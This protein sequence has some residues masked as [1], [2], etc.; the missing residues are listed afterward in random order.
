MAGALALKASEP[1]GADL[2]LASR[3]MSN[4]FVTNQITLKQVSNC[5]RSIN[6]TNLESKLPNDN[7]LTLLGQIFAHFFCR[8][9]VVIT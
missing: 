8:F 5:R 1:K 3:V 6:T 2:Q 9:V 7:L 4:V